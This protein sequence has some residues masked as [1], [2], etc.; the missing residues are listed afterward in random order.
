[1]SDD[2]RRSIRT[3]LHN[4]QGV[5]KQVEQEL[6][7][8]GLKI[9]EYETN[10]SIWKINSDKIAELDAQATSLNEK[11]GKL[12]TQLREPET[13]RLTIEQ[14][15]NLSKNAASIFKAANVVIKDR[16]ARYIFLNLTVD[17]EKVASYQLKEPFATLFKTRQLH[18]SRDAQI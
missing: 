6:K 9:I 4:H 5:L 13:D 12:G 7:E 18:T 8:R 14:F 2:K 3:Q 11:I 10:T 15:L 17:E 16:I 1:M